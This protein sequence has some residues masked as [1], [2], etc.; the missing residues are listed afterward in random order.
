MASNFKEVNKLN[1]LI[2]DC[3]EAIR[4]RGAHAKVTFTLPKK[5]K[6]R[7]AKATLPGGLEGTVLAETHDGKK[8]ICLFPAAKTLTKLEEI[9]NDII[10][11]GNRN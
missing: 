6:G 1:L 4:G 8:I 2:E 5:G 9:R 10:T 3:H 11:G 7:P